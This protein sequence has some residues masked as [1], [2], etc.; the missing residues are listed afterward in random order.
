[1]LIG[2]VLS[3]NSTLTMRIRTL[4]IEE[5]SIVGM[6]Q[7]GMKHKDF[8]GEMNMPLTIVSIVLKK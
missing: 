1:M 3:L 4:G 8:V 5:S 6:Q 2:F 7:I